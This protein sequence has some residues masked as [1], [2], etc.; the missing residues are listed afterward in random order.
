MC[1]KLIKHIGNVS[2]KQ[3]TAICIGKLISKNLLW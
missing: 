3:C 1:M 2:R